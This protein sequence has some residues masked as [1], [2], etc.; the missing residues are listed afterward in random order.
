MMAMTTSSSIK[1]KPD[2]HGTAIRLRSQPSAVAPLKGPGLKNEG[3]AFIGNYGLI[4][5]FLC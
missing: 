5:L 4:T 1:V 3:I 2:L